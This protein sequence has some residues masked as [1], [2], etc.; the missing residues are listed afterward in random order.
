MKSK[1]VS[2]VTTFSFQP[3]RPSALQSALSTHRSRAAEVAD[4]ARTLNWGSPLPAATSTAKRIIDLAGALVG[5]CIMA[6][7]VLPIAIAI[8]HDSPGPLFFR[9]LRYGYRGKPF[10]IWKFRSMVSDADANQHRV[11]NEA[12]GL[13]FKNRA[14]PRITRVGR[15]LR[16]TSLDELPQFINVLRGEMSLVGT[17]PPILNEVIQ[18]QPHHW[19][20]LAVKPGMTGKW[21]TSGRSSIKDFEDIVAMDMDYQAN[22]SI[23]RDLIIIFKTVAVVFGSK[24][25][26]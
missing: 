2:M 17:R 18:Y 10:L 11:Q 20:R 15:F 1:H 19:Q 13:I 24:D 25:A 16:R 5:L 22:W 23:W 3:E 21:Q 12:R 4:T 9:Q 7:L 26:C 14:D 8:R 6:V